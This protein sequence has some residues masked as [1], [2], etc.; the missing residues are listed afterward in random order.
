MY[1][2]TCS[3]CAVLL[4]QHFVE[5]LSDHFSR[6]F[7][8]CLDAF[9]SGFR[10]CHLLHLFLKIS[11]AVLYF[12]LCEVWS[13]I[14][15]VF[16]TALSSRCSFLFP[17]FEGLVLLLQADFRHDGLLQNLP[18]TFQQFLSLDVIVSPLSFCTFGMSVLF[19]PDFM[20]DVLWMTLNSIQNPLYLYLSF[21]SLLSLMHFL[22]LLLNSFSWWFVSFHNVSPLLNESSD[23]IVSFIRSFQFLFSCD[24]DITPVLSAFSLDAAAAAF[25]S[26]LTIA[27]LLLLQ[28]R[29]CFQLALFLLLGRSRLHSKWRAPASS[30][31]SPPISTFEL[32]GCGVRVFIRMECCCGFLNKSSRFASSLQLRRLCL[33]CGGVMLQLQHRQ[34]LLLASTLSKT[35]SFSASVWLLQ[36]RLHA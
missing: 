16:V 23:L 8:A 33:R 14:S 3:W 10:C 17:S 19:L 13:F 34:L 6:R 27:C 7:V 29:V 30:T 32:G 24:L 26:S 36:L 18:K 15:H 5:D 31:T 28:Q 1:S 22:I 21:C 12:I 9:G 35:Q 11:M 2:S 25:V 4:L 20:H